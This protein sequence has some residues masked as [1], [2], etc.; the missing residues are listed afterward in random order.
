M[1]VIGFVAAVFAGEAGAEQR[2]G[3]QIASATADPIG[4]TLVQDG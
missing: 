3:V 1:I 4:A 2:I